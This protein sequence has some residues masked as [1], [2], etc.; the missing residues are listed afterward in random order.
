[1]TDFGARSSSDSITTKH[2]GRN[3]DPSHSLNCPAVRLTRCCLPSFRNCITPS[4]A[5]NEVARLS[6]IPEYGTLADR[7]NSQNQTPNSTS[8]FN[9]RSFFDPL[10]HSFI[11]FTSSYEALIE[12]RLKPHG[13]PPRR[14]EN[15]PLR[16]LLEKKNP[17]QNNETSNLP[18]P[19]PLVDK[20][21]HLLHFPKTHP[22]LLRHRPNGWKIFIYHFK[23]TPES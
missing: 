21:P 8:N 11:E 5:S 23:F 22:S 16:A 7:F 2:R 19:F 18:T 9:S 6:A 15:P 1:M 14:L 20:T 3:V 13:S 17:T 4:V 12:D 10:V